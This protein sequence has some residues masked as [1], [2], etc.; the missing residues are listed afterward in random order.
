LLDQPDLLPSARTLAAAL[1]AP[2]L[3][4]PVPAGFSRRA[5]G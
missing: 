4:R 2:W 1:V 5:A 3:E